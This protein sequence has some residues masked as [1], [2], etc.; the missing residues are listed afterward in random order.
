VNRN[1]VF[2]ICGTLFEANTTNDFIYFISRKN[3]FNKLIFTSRSVFIFNIFLKKIFKVNLLRKYYLYGLKGY[4]YEELLI[5]AEKFYEDFLTNHK[6]KYT[7]DLLYKVKESGARVFLASA[8]ISP[9]CEV[10]AKKLGVDDFVSSN[11]E[12]ENGV[13]TGKLVLNLAGKKLKK[14]N[15]ESI[16]LVIT[17]NVSDISLIMKAEKVIVVTKKPKKE[18]WDKLL[19]TSNFQAVVKYYLK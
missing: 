3:I 7:H 18:S 2:D 5:L 1:I 16:E 8:T 4:T 17:D 12:F 19:A 6:I 15:L 14:L 13:S 11:L 10:I 9:V